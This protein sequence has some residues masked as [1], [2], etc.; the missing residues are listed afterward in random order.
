MELLGEKIRGFRIEKALSQEELSEL[1]GVNVRTIQRVESGKVQPR[2]NTLKLICNALEIEITELE[3]SQFPTSETNLVLFYISSLSFIVIPAGNLILPII[4]W[5]SQKNKS[6][7]FEEMGK[8]LLNFQ[9]SWSVIVFLCSMVVAFLK[10]QH[11]ATSVA[12][13]IIKLIYVL[14]VS[15]IA[16]TILSSLKI[17]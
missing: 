9:I 10:I 4:I 2:G 1:A 16:L 17:K 8:Q 14:I 11:I 7:H 6:K 12:D 13:I 3:L 5:F 15:N